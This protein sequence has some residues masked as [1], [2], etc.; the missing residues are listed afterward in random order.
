V[1]LV[2]TDVSEEGIASIIR[3]KRISELGSALAVTSN[4]RSVRRN[5]IVFL[6]RVL[7]AV[8]IAK[9][10]P[11]SL[12]LFILIMEAISSSEMSVLTR[13]TLGHITE[14]VILQNI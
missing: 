8:V 2:R 11:S 1:A 9:V 3:A 12:I 10:V 6:R 7:Q 4:R 13:V 5:E 14:D